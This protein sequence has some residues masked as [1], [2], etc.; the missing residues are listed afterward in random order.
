[1]VSEDGG[2]YKCREGGGSEREKIRN[3]MSSFEADR[4]ME[5][6]K[7]RISLNIDD[8]H[9]FPQMIPET[10]LRLVKMNVAGNHEATVVSPFSK[11]EY[12]RKK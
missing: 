12:L 2:N 4:Y 5:K 11:K 1:M 10:L 9:E 7:A 6:I 8:A 3:S